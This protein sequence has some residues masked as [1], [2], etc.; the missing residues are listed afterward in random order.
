MPPRLKNGKESVIMEN[1][2][3]PQETDTAAAARASLVALG[4]ALVALGFV[5]LLLPPL[6]S[7][8]TTVVI[9]VILAVSGIFEG[10]HALRDRH[11]PHFAWQF[12]SALIRIVAGILIVLRPIA[13]TVVLT[14][15]LATYFLVMG[16]VKI[17]RAVQMRDAPRWGWVLFDGIVSVLIGAFVWA[18]WPIS[19][20][21]LVGV[22]VAVELI[23]AGSTSLALGAALRAP[24]LPR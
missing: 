18:S 15:I 20:I 3:F 23:V 11:S 19:S 5:A 7:L 4:I 16:G 22:L 8:V 12:I 10:I 13:G 14:A 9:G 6:F 24:A 21:W 2:V 17:I 1:P